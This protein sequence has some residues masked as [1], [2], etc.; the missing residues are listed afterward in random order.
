MPTSS[1]SGLIPVNLKK[2]RGKNE[3][4]AAAEAAV[5]FIMPGTDKWENEKLVETG[6]RLEN[7]LETGGKIEIS[8]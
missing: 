2:R 6:E 8:G 4:T 7:R 3:N 5:F 1:M